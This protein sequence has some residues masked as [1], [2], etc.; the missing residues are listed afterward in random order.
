MRGELN[1][2]FIKRLRL[3][4]PPLKYGDKGKLLFATEDDPHT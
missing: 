1:D 3:A 4:R 2:G